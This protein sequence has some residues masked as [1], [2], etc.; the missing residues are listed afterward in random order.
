[1]PRWPEFTVTVVTV[2]MLAAD[3][4][5][6]ISTAEGLSPT[7]RNKV[8]PAGSDDASAKFKMDSRS[9]LI[10]VAAATAVTVLDAHI[11]GRADADGRA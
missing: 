11:R 3:S 5:D 7:L 4:A 10:R 2:A 6:G 8:Q 1:M 9:M